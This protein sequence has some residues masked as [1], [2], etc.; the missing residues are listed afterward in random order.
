M[1]QQVPTLPL[2]AGNF[3]SIVASQPTAPASSAEL[4][5]VP[6]QAL[7]VPSLPVF[8]D[9]VAMPYAQ[10]SVQAPRHESHLA[11]QQASG[12]P[13]PPIVAAEFSIDA[14]EEEE[15]DTDLFGSPEM[16]T[17]LALP[18]VPAVQ[19]GTIIADVRVDGS[20]LGFDAAALDMSYDDWMNPAVYADP[21][22][23][24]SPFEGLFL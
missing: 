18:P 12:S 16:S 4:S 10:V 22:M 8:A 14:K 6:Q 19:E 11:P 13:P 7:G 21:N 20:A 1:Q 23:D 9:E 5:S 17:S 24:F 15:Y 3:S 2:S